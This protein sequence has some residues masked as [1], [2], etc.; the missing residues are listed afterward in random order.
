[1][2]VDCG[3]ARHFCDDPVCPDPV[4]KPVSIVGYEHM[5]FEI[6]MMT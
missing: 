2:K 3:E 4:R 6:G 5:F 1:M